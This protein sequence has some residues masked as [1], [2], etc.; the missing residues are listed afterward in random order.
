MFGSWSP[1][2]TPG[3]GRLGTGAGNLLAACP[4]IRSGAQLVGWVA[5]TSV[6]GRSGPGNG[7]QEITL[8]CREAAQSVGEDTRNRCQD[9]LEHGAKGILKTSQTR[10]FND[11][12]PGRGIREPEAGMLAQH[13]GG[14]GDGQ[15]WPGASPAWQHA[16]ELR[17]LVQTTSLDVDFLLGPATLTTDLDEDCG[18][19]GEGCGAHGVMLHPGH[20]KLVDIE[21]VSQRS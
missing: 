15:A 6:R 4:L 19:P 3:Y 20:Q 16:D 14:L 11:R 7:R 10:S 5:R 2:D 13:I 1:R 18:D 21:T 9:F 17:D 12:R 8:D